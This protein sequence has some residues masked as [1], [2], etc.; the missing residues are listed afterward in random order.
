MRS[1]GVV[2]LVDSLGQRVPL[3]DKGVPS[4]V[5]YRALRCRFQQPR[6]IPPI[7]PWSPCR[8]LESMLAS[9]S[10]VGS[11]KRTIRR[12]V[13]WPYWHSPAHSPR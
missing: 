1:H 3:R 13:L 6:G 7:I 4:A 8:S 11:V 5:P 2:R 10:A 9:S 12:G